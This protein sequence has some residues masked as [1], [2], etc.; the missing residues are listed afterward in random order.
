MAFRT[1]DIYKK[2]PEPGS[3]LNEA[4]PEVYG[5][6]RSLIPDET[7]VLIGFYKDEEHLNW[8]CKNKIYNTRI[9]DARGSVKLGIGESSAKYLLL[10]THGEIIQ[11]SSLK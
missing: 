10:H 3:E 5:D 11:V 8:I 2:P 1:Y 4:L 7:F 6:N 9:A